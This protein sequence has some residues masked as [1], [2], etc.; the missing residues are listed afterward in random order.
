MRIILLF[1]WLLLLAQVASG[2]AEVLRHFE[3]AEGT[4]PHGTPVVQNSTVYGTTVYGGSNGYGTIYRV[5]SDGSGFIVLHHFSGANG[6]Y[7]VAGLVRRGQILYGVAAY[8]GAGGAGVTF[9]IRLDGTGFRVLNHFKGIRGVN[10][11]SRLHLAQFGPV[12]YLYG[13]TTNGGANGTGVIFRLRTNGTGFSV[14]HHFSSGPLGTRPAGGVVRVGTKL[15]GVAG[16][17]GAYDGGLLY[18]LNDS[19]GGFTVLRHQA[20]SGGGGAGF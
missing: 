6:A 16:S 5:A 11:Y 20:V 8:G 9:R 10:P 15:Y 13:T 7:P 14:V 18:R 12:W 1:G 17:G 4:N 3:L 2:Q 19:G